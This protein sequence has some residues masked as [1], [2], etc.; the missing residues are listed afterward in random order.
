M[1]GALFPDIRDLNLYK[2]Q[3]RNDISTAVD[4][5]TT[6]DMCVKYKWAGY[7][8]SRIFARLLGCENRALTIGLA[9]F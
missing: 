1:N 4:V 7:L 8:D 5:L 9:P 3:Q 6:P 2:G